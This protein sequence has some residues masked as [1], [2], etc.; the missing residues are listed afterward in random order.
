MKKTYGFTII[1]LLLGL[2][3]FS[4]IIVLVYSVFYNGLK[5]EKRA[6]Q[7]ESMLHEARMM[8]GLM[9]KEFENMTTYNFEGSNEDKQ[10]FEGREDSIQFVL[11]FEQ[12]LK[13]VRYSLENKNQ[14]VLYQTIIGETYSK[15]MDTIT[16]QRQSQSSY[17]L[18]RSEQNFVS[19]LSGSNKG[20]EKEILLT[21]LESDSFQ[22]SYG[23]IEGEEV[24][25][26]DEWED[27][28]I[29]SIIKISFSVFDSTKGESVVFEKAVLIPIGALEDE[30]IEDE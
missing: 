21:Q 23:K 12:G 15:N 14:S 25:Y 18:I 1:E 13:V 4:I 9:E 26:L 19:F 28:R 5:L 17:V 8:L 22:F 7:N 3:I 6:N 10:S 20:A 29:P 27:A 16:K 2:S 30:E 24:S 11:A